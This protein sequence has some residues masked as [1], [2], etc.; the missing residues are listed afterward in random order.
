MNW[1]NDPT[2]NVGF[3]TTHDPTIAQGGIITYYKTLSIIQGISI[4]TLA[5][6][7][8]HEAVVASVATFLTT[9]H[10]VLINYLRKFR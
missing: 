5:Y 6:S 7:I 8:T 10:R 4:L 9:G 3:R 1:T 2:R